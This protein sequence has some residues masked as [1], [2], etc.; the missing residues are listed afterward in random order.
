MKLVQPICRDG[1]TNADLA[2]LQS[3]LTPDGSAAEAL[4]TLIADPA[5]RDELLDL[6]E[7]FQAVLEQPLPITISPR[8]YFFVLVRHR[9][10]ESGLEDRELAD[11]VA[12]LMANSMATSRVF[13]TGQGNARQAP[14]YAIDDMSRIQSAGFCERFYLTVCL[15][16]KSLV[17]TGLFRPHLDYRAT[18]RGAPNLRYYENIGQAH[19]RAA[20]GHHLA[21]EYCLSD[22]YQALAARFTEARRALNYVAETLTF[23][24]QDGPN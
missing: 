5:M 20:G 24:G 23:M 6:P 12:S 4:L 11:Y 7:V 13:D 9:F 19:Y 14:F 16:E 17:V 8:L 15:A 10:V 2:F 22:C 21:Q 18:Y 3:V 1:L